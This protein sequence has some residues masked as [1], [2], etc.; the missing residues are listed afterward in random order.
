[1]LILFTPNLGGWSSTSSS[2]ILLRR[3]V[4]DIGYRQ[5]TIIGASNANHIMPWSGLQWRTEAERRVET[6]GIQG[7]QTPARG[8]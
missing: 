6:S 5:Y 4:T 1:M 3:S 2:L 7:R 8:G